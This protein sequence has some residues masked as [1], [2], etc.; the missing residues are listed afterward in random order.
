MLMRPS[1]AQAEPAVSDAHGDE[2][3]P[4]S[5]SDHEFP[6][7]LLLAEEDDLLSDQRRRRSLS[8]DA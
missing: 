3:E 2:V 1:A 5:E 8:A 4:S 6:E 7:N